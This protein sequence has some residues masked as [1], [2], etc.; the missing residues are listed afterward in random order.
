MN[1][2]IERKRRKIKQLC[3][4]SSTFQNEKVTIH[5]KSS[6]RTKEISTLT[7]RHVKYKVMIML[8]CDDTNE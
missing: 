3:I 2:S 5:L 6:L 4:R 7:R 8:F 1:D